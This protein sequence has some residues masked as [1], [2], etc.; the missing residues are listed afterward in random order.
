MLEA[1]PVG[2]FL[3]DAS[4]HI[5]EINEAVRTIWGR[6]PPQVEGIAEYAVYRAWRPGGEVP[7]APEDWG[8]AR[9]LTRGEVCLAEELEIETFDGVRRTILNSSVPI[10]NERGTLLGGAAVNVDITDR[11]RAELEL[12]ALKDQLEDRVRART[13]ELAAA[14]A[15]LQAFSYSVSHDLRAP[16]RWVDGFTRALAEDYADRLDEAGREYVRHIRGSVQRM[17][18]L[19]DA[20]LELSRIARAPLTRTEVDLTAMAWGIADD[21]AASEP[22]R[23]VSWTIHPELRARGDPQ[24]IRVALDNLLRNAWKF[25]RT[26]DDAHIEVGAARRDGETAYFVCDD[27]V[28]FDMTYADKLFRSFERLHR[29]DDFEGTGIG[30]ALV[31]RIA[32]RHGGTVGAEGQPDRGAT[33]WFT[34]APPEECG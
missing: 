11:K 27:G 16:L 20:L 26:R 3:A 23:R 14:N 30:L 32:Q 4:G 7:L 28:G 34:L 13:A 24:L 33:F 2:V 31:K 9:T 12:T 21:L 8:L 5:D 17:A 15:E 10:R 25:T 22:T 1:L 29:S 6:Q 18:E 19:I